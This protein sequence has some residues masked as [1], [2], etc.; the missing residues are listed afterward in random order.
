MPCYYPIKGWFSKTKNPSGK[1]SIVFN[2]SEA[3]VDMP[4]NVPCGQCIGCRLERSRD[5]A[6]RCV[7][8]ASL[9]KDNCFITL[10]F[11]DE[12]LNPEGTLVKSDFQKF[13][14]RLRK[15]F[16]SG[17][18]FFH[19]GEYGD[20]LSRPHHHACLFNFNFPDRVLWR[21]KNGFKLYRS[22]IL[23]EL[24]PF[25]FCTVGD[26][27]FE[28]AAYVARYVVKKI[29]GKEKKA[30]YGNLVPEYTTMSRKPGIAYDWFKRFKSDVYPDDFIVVR[31]NFK[32]KP[33]KYYDYL[34]G[35]SD[36]NEFNKIKFKRKKET[37][38][39][40]EFYTDRLIVKEKIANSK[41]KRKGREYETNG[42]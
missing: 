6:V 20:K 11:S 25:G 40:P 31:N 37:I 38:D 27:T 30:H 26:V 29:N 34:L 17:I 35:L 3:F 19:C 5:W 39:N 22:A 8:E 36:I 32:S 15:R 12:F 42:I 16:G 23:E 10:T 28:S 1:R 24:W 41:L 4:V 2:R 13:M 33:P 18:R 9:W 21:E 14:K 7:H